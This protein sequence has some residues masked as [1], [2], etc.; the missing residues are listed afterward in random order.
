MIQKW[1]NRSEHDWQCT[2]T[3]RVY[4]VSHITDYIRTLSNIIKF[5][6]SIR[7]HTNSPSIS[8]LAMTSSQTLLVAVPV[9]AMQGTG[10]REHK[11]SKGRSEVFDMHTVYETH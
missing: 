5:V 8:R 9:H 7:R 4:K 3:C 2:I 11:P 1:A 10:I 6:D